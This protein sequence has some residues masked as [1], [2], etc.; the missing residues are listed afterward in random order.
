MNWSQ[1]FRLNLRKYPSYGIALLFLF[2][3][4]MLALLIPL[5]PLT[6]TQRTYRIFQHCQVV[7]IGLVPM[8]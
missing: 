7:L 1:R 5:F 4:F 3:I 8:S 2:V 6:Q